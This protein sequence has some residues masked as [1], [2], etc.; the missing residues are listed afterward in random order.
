MDPRKI[1]TVE[2]AE[3]IISSISYDGFRPPSK[4]VVI[5]MKNTLDATFACFSASDYEHAIY[6]CYRATGKIP[7]NKSSGNP[8][9][10]TACHKSFSALDTE[11]QIHPR[12]VRYIYDAMLHLF[13]EKPDN[14]LL[15][16][17]YKLKRR[18]VHPR[19]QAAVTGL[20]AIAEEE[21]IS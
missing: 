21:S 13:K 8:L 12:T 3:K 6:N 7:I 16:T 1:P 15:E 14:L 18:S 2:I 5:D 20:I 10:I 11:D 17:L 9:T 19:W 4:D